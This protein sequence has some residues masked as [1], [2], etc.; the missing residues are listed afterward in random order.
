[1]FYSI[2][3]EFEILCVHIFCLCRIF[4]FNCPYSWSHAWDVKILTENNVFSVKS[5][6][7]LVS[8]I[9]N[10]YILNSNMK[11]VFQM[12]NLSCSNWHYSSISSHR[13]CEELKRILYEN[14]QNSRGISRPSSQQIP[15]H[16]RNRI[17]AGVN[18]RAKIATC[19]SKCFFSKTM[20]WIVKAFSRLEVDLCFQFHLITR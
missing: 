9:T 11:Q 8:F 17:A 19:M 14:H 15:K 18:S 20:Q 16:D 1:M 6:A 2:R 4:F 12:R 13:R 3:K 5:N 7:F 10:D